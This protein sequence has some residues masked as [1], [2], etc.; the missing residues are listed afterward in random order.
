MA[1]LQLFKVVLSFTGNAHS[2]VRRTREPQTIPRPDVSGER[3][4]GGI[5]GLLAGSLLPLHFLERREVSIISK[6]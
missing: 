2:S 5:L 4:P 1:G 6:R 3:I